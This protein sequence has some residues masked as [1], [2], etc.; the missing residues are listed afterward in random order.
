MLVWTI[1]PK[2]EIDTLKKTFRINLYIY[3][4]IYL[5]GGVSIGGGDTFSMAKLFSNIFFLKTRMIPV[6][7]NCWNY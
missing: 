2:V 4:R 5:L 1:N 6:S 7:N 3:I